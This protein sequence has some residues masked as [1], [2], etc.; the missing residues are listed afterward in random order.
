MKHLKKRFS[1]IKYKILILLGL[2]I[3]FTFIYTFFD[4]SNFGGIN[5]LQDLIKEEVIKEE[6]KKK[7]ENFRVKHNG[8]DNQHE[9]T[10]KETT[11]QSVK[12]IKSEELKK[13]NIK[14]SL[15]QRIFKRLYFS[16]ITGTTLG[17]G[18]IY[19]VSNAV[20]SISMVHCLSTIIL[21]LF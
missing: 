3:L 14:P 19:P 18:D 16:V 8:D 10:L 9:K 2:V 1:H 21:I 7:I 5:T 11:E 4:D 20:K 12:Q 15:G 13:E 6:V 17:Y